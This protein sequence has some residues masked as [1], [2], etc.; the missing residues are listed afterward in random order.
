MRLRLGLTHFGWREDV[1]NLVANGTQDMK[2]AYEYS[3]SVERESPMVNLFKE[4]LGKTDQEVDQLFNYCNSL[5][6]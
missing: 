3:V 5:I 2:D 4:N 6:V 1:E